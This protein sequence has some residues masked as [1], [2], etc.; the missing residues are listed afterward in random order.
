MWHG[1]IPGSSSQL[2]PGE[3]SVP[4]RTCTTKAKLYYQQLI[5][6][7][8]QE[9]G[10]VTTHSFQKVQSVDRALL[11]SNPFCLCAV[12]ISTVQ[13]CTSYPVHHN[14]AVLTS[15]GVAPFHSPITPSVATT[16]LMTDA[17][18]L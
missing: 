9:D 18:L 6:Q 5:C 4:C 2:Q 17:A 1:K 11:T 12:C 14:T 15:P 7:Q 10:Q 13:W 16:L 3:R 8:A